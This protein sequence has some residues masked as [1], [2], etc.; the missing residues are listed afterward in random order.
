[1]A[2]KP[3]FKETIPK[4]MKPEPHQANEL[5]KPITSWKQEIADFFGFKLKEGEPG[6]GSR[7]KNLMQAGVIV[8]G[9]AITN[10]EGVCLTPELSKLEPLGKGLKE[11]RARFYG[12][13]G[14]DLSAFN[15][16]QLVELVPTLAL[17]VPP[18]LPRVSLRRSESGQG[19][20]GD[21]KMEN[22]SG[23]F[24]ESPE[25]FPYQLTGIK[26]GLVLKMEVRDTNEVFNNLRIGPLCAPMQ[27]QRING[28]GVIHGLADVLTVLIADEDATVLVYGP[29]CD[30]RNFQVRL[31]ASD[32]E[33]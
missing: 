20:Q 24:E 13:N 14:Q 15:P 12:L 8:T 1:M 6:L 22:L 33:E 2:F 32:E 21:E 28:E 7:A 23:S 26:I 11:G 31:L 27:S 29:V 3:E 16:G 9:S 5:K 18:Y 17:R 10:M 4:R 30:P 25:R 19:G